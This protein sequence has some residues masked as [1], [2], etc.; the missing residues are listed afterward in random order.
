MFLFANV[1]AKTVP[2]SMITA[3]YYEL[4]KRISFSVFTRS[5][6]ITDVCITYHRLAYVWFR[7]YKHQPEEVL[8]TCHMG[9]FFSFLHSF[10]YLSITFFRRK[11]RIHDF[12]EANSAKV[13]WTDQAE[14]WTRPADST[15]HANNC[16]DACTIPYRKWLQNWNAFQ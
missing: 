2:T 14:I 6:I 12:P 4:G 7:R 13:N 3:Y 8:V 5:K 10:I 15:F 1:K 9:F 16:Y 11:R